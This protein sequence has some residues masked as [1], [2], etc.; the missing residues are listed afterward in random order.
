MV[1]AHAAAARTGGRMPPE[2]F[3][4]FDPFGGTAGNGPAIEQGGN[5]REP[6][7]TISMAHDT[8]W[9]LGRYM[10]VGPLAQLDSLQPTERYQMKRMGMAGLFNGDEAVSFN[11]ARPVNPFDPAD[12][13]RG[14]TDDLIFSAVRNA[15]GRENLYRG[16]S[17]NMWGDENYK[18]NPNL[19]DWRV[20]FRPEYQRNVRGPTDD[21]TS[22]AEAETFRGPGV[23]GNTLGWLNE[24]HSPGH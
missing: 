18:I 16:W 24:H 20:Q 15:S 22:F 3:L 12:R 7:S 14:T 21:A 2:F 19:R 9:S 1:W 4:D 13:Q 8:D 11:P 10:G 17:P 6:M 23:E 5:A